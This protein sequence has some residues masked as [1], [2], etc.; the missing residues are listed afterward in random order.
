MRSLAA[1]FSTPFKRVASLYADTI[2]AQ[3]AVGRAPKRA[4][5]A[6]PEEGGSNSAWV[7]SGAGD[8]ELEEPAGTRQEEKGELEFQAKGAHMQ[9]HRD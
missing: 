2:S 4:P 8:R 5:S 3:W 1:P 6:W 9:R 7:V